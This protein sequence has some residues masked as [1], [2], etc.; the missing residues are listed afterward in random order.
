MSTV[1]DAVTAKLGPLPAW[2]WGV[3]GAA[4]LRGYSWWRGRQA[5]ATPAV[6][7]G[8]T[9]EAA[10][11]EP[12]SSASV[13]TYEPNVPA[14]APINL[15]PSTSTPATSTPPASPVRYTDNEAWR[16]AAIDLLVSRGVG[17]GDA[18]EA[19][20]AILAG[21]TVTGVQ[22]SMFN[23]AVNAIGAPPETVPPIKTREP[24]SYTP[25]PRPRAGDPATPTSPEPATT[26]AQPSSGTYTIKA[27]DTLVG[28]ARARYGNAN[29]STLDKLAALNN[30]TWNSA[31][32]MVTPFRVGQVLTL[33]AT[34]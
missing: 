21:D 26:P 24:I 10:A 23:T 2:A 12:P 5:P 27:G 20:R 29:R 30:L 19:M 16:R 32:T 28:V 31:H 14:I 17:A 7:T 3:L 9:E 18:V 8:G 33:P 4:G 6:D 22:V 25:Q 11:T 34:L 1:T 13:R 15:T